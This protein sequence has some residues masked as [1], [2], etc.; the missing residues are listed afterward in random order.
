LPFWRRSIDVDPRQPKIAAAF[1]FF[2]AAGWTLLGFVL[3]FAPGR[4]VVTALSISAAAI[5][6]QYWSWWRLG[7]HALLLMPHPLRQIARLV[8]V[9]DFISIA[10]VYGV[11][12]WILMAIAIRWDKGAAFPSHH[13]AWVATLGEVLV[14]L[15]MGPFL[16][17]RIITPP[18]T[19]T[20]RARFGFGRNVARRFPVDL[21]LEHWALEA[22]VAFGTLGVMA[23]LYDRLG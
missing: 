4:W 6:L 10:S 13:H 15:A 8:G 18:R 3:A 21:P 5:A 16:V 2:G 17:V 1:V 12:A 23:G 9:P 14:I 22:M 7:G 11:V 20:R 19:L